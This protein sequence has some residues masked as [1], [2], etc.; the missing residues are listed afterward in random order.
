MRE[1]ERLLAVAVNAGVMAFVYLVEGELFDWG[2]SV[3]DCREAETAEARVH[4]WIRFYKPDL[5]VLEELGPRSR[6]GKNAEALLGAGRKAAEK[7]RVHSVSIARRYSEPN[8]YAEA[9]RLAEEF[10]QLAP[11]LPPP[12]RIWEKEP[13]QIIYFE[14]LSLA[15]KWL[16]ESGRMSTIE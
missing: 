4:S 5:I 16:K 15:A 8:K 9:A 12:R 2:L 3:K 1:P 14:A 13:R 7:A 11:W 10:P 6:K